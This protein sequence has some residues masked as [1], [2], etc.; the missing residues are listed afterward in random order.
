[1]ISEQS[2]EAVL[3]CQLVVDLFIHWTGVLSPT[4]GY[5]N[6][7]VNNIVVW[8]MSVNREMAKIV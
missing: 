1:M 5:F 3:L 4:E 2:D 8:D 7:A 6:D